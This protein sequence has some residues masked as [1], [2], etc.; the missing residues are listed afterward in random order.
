MQETTRTRRL[1]QSSSEIEASM[2]EDDR[3][4]S[5]RSRINTLISCTRELVLDGI[6]ARERGVEQDVS[7]FCCVDSL[8]IHVECSKLTEGRI[9]F[10]PHT[11]AGKCAR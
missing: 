8:L 4:Y 5:R 3:V 2:I 1:L 6:G 10:A 9:V 11:E 7:N